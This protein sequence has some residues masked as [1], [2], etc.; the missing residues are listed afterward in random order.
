M[1]SNLTAISDDIAYTVPIEIRPGTVVG[2]HCGEGYQVAINAV[3]QDDRT[4][5]VQGQ[6]VQSE[7]CV[8][9]C[10]C[11]FVCV[12]VYVCVR[13]CVRACVH[14]YV[15]QWVCG[16]VCACVY[17]CVNVGVLWCTCMS[18]FYELCTT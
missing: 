1:A 5:G 15:V 14:A 8:R 11:V 16:C 7:Q 6:C 2:T 9:A 12:C 18:I 10:V 4:W 17:T 3:C 13:A